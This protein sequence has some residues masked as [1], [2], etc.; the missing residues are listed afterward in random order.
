MPRGCFSLAV[1]A[2]AAGRPA[3]QLCTVCRLV[4]RPA[5]SREGCCNCKVSVCNPGV[6]TEIPSPPRRSSCSGL[7]ESLRC[8]SLA[9]AAPESEVRL[10]AAVPGN[11]C[12]SGGFCSHALTTV[13]RVRVFTSRVIYYRHALLMLSEE[14]KSPRCFIQ[15]C[16]FELAGWEFA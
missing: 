5:P 16:G 4:C 11:F 6:G 12:R 9:K 8:S 10:R 15:T 3:P 1:R 7:S 2:C 14:E 13:K